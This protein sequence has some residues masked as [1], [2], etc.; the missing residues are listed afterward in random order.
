MFVEQVKKENSNSLHI[1]DTHLQRIAARHFLESENAAW[2]FLPP[3][4]SE[5]EPS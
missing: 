4:V 5:S 3:I 2:I 1:A